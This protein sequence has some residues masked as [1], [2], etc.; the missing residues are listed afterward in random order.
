MSSVAI[1]LTKS[2]HGSRRV[3]SSKNHSMWLRLP[4]HPEYSW[5]DELRALIREAKEKMRETSTGHIEKAESLMS[6]QYEKP[7]LFGNNN[8]PRSSNSKGMS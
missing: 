7:G 5:L 4:P 2:L 3:G 6:F 8:E 1:R